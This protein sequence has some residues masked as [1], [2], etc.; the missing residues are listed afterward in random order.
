MIKRLLTGICLV[1][2]ILSFCVRNAIAFAIPDVTPLSEIPQI[3]PFGLLASIDKSREML[4]MLNT[5]K[6]KVKKVKEETRIEGIKKQAAKFKK[7]MLNLKNN[8]KVTSGSVTI[9]EIQSID[10]DNEAA[11]AEL[12]EELFLQYPDTDSKVM[13]DYQAVGETFKIASTLQTYIT[14]KQ[15]EREVDK[16]L[17]QLDHVEECLFETKNCE[18]AGLDDS[19]SCEKE[20]ESEDNA[21]LWRGEL[22]VSQ[23]YD[24]IMYYNEYLFS[25]E[26]QYKAT[27]SIGDTVKIREYQEQNKNKEE[28]H[29]ALRF[30]P[31]VME[32]SA[33]LTWNQNYA[34]GWYEGSPENKEVVK[35]GEFE[36]L[37]GVG[38]FVGSLH[39]KKESFDSLAEIETA[40][41]AV[42]KALQAHNAKNKLPSYRQVYEQYHQLENYY[43][44]IV[45]NQALSEQCV[46]NYIGQYYSNAAQAWAGNGCTNVEGYMICRYPEDEKEKRGFADVSCPNGDAGR[47]YM[48][49]LTDT[50]G[51]S[52]LSGYLLSLYAET[53]KQANDEDIDAFINGDF[54]DNFN[55]SG[56]NLV[57]PR[58][59]S[60]QDRSEKRNSP[61]DNMANP[62]TENENADENHNYKNPLD[63]ENAAAEMRASGML[64]WLNGSIVSKAMVND[65]NSLQNAQFGSIKNRYPLW[66]DQKEFY[67]Q[68]INGKYENMK[69]YIATVPLN[70]LLVEAAQIANELLDY[71]Q[72][73]ENPM[74]DMKTVEA[75]KIGELADSLGKGAE[76]EDEIEKMIAEEK[77]VLQNMS[78][79]H[80]SA[81]AEI[82]L[83][84]ENV[85]AKI[86]ELNKKLD[87]TNKEYNEQNELMDDAEET[88]PLDEEAVHNEREMYKK[89]ELKDGEDLVSP[90]ENS[91]H[92]HKENNDEKWINASVKQDSLADDSLSVKAKIE[93]YQTKFDNLKDD[94]NQEIKK[95]V[96]AYDETVRDYRQKVQAALDKK[97]SDS[98]LNLVA[99]AASEIKAVGV[100]ENVVQCVRKKVIQKIDDAKQK[101]QA[102]QDSDDIYYSENTGR[103]QR[104][105]NEM[106]EDIMSMA[107]EKEGEQASSTPA[108]CGNLEDEI[109][110]EMTQSVFVKALMSMCENDYCTTPEENTESGP[111]YFVG[112]EGKPRDFRTPS[113]PL[114]YS[115]APLR[116]IFY[117]D[118]Y[119]YD[120]VERYFAGDEEP[121]DNREIIIT[122]ESF[123]ESGAEMPE[124]W[125][126]LLKVRTFE[127]KELDIAALFERG[128]A[129]IAYSRSGIFPCKLNGKIIDAALA[130]QNDIYLFGYN[131]NGKKE[132]VIEQNCAAVQYENGKLIDTQTDYAEV[133]INQ[134]EDDVSQ[135]SELAQILAYVPPSGSKVVPLLGFMP[136]PEIEDKSQYH[137][138]FNR[139][140]ISSICQDVEAEE[141][142]ATM[143]QITYA[144]RTLFTTNQFGN[145]LEWIERKEQ[146]NE[147]MEK[148]RKQMEEIKAQ[149]QEIFNDFGDTLSDDFDLSSE[150]DYTMAAT[151]LDSYKTAYIR[152]AKEQ[153]SIAGPRQTID[154]IKERLTEIANKLALLLLDDDEMAEISGS[155]DKSELEYNIKQATANAGI[156]DKYHE[157]D[158]E[159]WEK[160]IRQI[161]KPYCA[162]YT[163]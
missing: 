83:Q 19:Y 71:P 15:M 25:L 70:D 64:N 112:I 106:I 2:F 74:L 23:M 27:M 122:G 34:D 163:K 82:R 121:K 16:L 12:F 3:S 11:I 100:A 157:K 28:Q 148:L 108:G 53:K 5:T 127:E 129:D 20:R 78:N 119:D 63:E 52:G 72:D 40:E 67:D 47:C 66:N 95:Y 84:M 102:M 46:I 88:T 86:E 132:N 160:R 142:D 30:Y 9:K 155:E 31:Q 128:N 7:G 56:D 130:E 90:Q 161:P 131:P 123:L 98:T 139:A 36:V 137:L 77:Q 41:Q 18:A 57:T 58:D 92:E 61:F 22:I 42:R 94:M 38:G 117:F 76:Q 113:G 6:E 143:E 114:S 135:S 93:I 79:A 146:T 59:G 147:A 14:A 43:N 111:V 138:S 162:V 69:Q 149:L 26:A 104:I 13:A 1:V 8:K 116:E 101:L 133:M 120:N 103:I 35:E 45:E 134:L 96:K 85:A 48:T 105:H 65:I 17:E 159:M 33:T 68:Y 150:E 136:Q 109:L 50:T 107:E 99:S 55:S 32:A 60:R 29:S 4:R 37:D 126:Y 115:S 144:L 158:M 145:Y 21:C 153:V 24:Q 81:K 97:Q 44:K 49:E 152:N 124:V 73:P 62:Q 110:A 80:K 87:E 51:R 141:N 39:D 89:R 151:T 54:D 91:R 75:D 140:F 154:Y 125:K 156:V 118:E 10:M